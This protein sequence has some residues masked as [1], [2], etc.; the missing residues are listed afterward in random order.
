MLMRGME[1]FRDLMFGE[2]LAGL[3][4]V[5]YHLQPLAWTSGV[6]AIAKARK[7]FDLVLFLVWGVSNQLEL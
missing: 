6:V 1:S 4:V 7:S 3:G 2:R 5:V